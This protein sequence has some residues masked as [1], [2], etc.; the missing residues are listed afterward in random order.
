MQQDTS[1]LRLGYTIHGKGT[2]EWDGASD[3]FS[4]YLD[5]TPERERRYSSTAELVADKGYYVQYDIGRILSVP[6]MG[7]FLGWTLIESNN[8]P[9]ESLRNGK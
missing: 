3:A 4:Q 7:S 1:G 8:R 9:I 2:C 6:L 5:Q